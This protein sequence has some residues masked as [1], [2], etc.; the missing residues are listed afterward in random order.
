MNV[1]VVGGGK[2]VYYLSRSLTGR[3]RHVT[4]VNR[5]RAE[6]RRLARRLD[7]TVVLGD[8]SDPTVL[9]KPGRMR[10]TR[11]WPSRPTM[12]TTS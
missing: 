5:N 4:I 9:E 3:G 6:C 2:L 10:P 11:C 12:R 8:G 1:L 7:A